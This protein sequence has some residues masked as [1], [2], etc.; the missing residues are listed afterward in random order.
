[1][2]TSKELV[3]SFVPHS[4]EE[5]NSGLQVLFDFPNGYTASVVRGPYTYGGDVGLW[6]VAVLFHGDLCYDTP[7]TDDVLGYLTQEEVQVALEQISK[8]PAR[9]EKRPELDA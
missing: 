3:V 5:K 1:M 2:L 6:E 4:I 8:L 7:I 9:T